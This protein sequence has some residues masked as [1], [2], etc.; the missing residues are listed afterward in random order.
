MPELK[1]RKSYSSPTIVGP[2]PEG[3]AQGRTDRL[4]LL[5]ASREVGKKRAQQE[6][7]RSRKEIQRVH[8]SEGF[9]HSPRSTQ[10]KGN[11]VEITR[12]SRPGRGK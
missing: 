5:E 2:V 6:R 1:L 8:K 3:E 7:A 10:R 9:D 12:K 11:S 4:Y